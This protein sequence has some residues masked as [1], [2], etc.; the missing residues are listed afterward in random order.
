LDSFYVPATPNNDNIRMD[1]NM[2][3]AKSSEGKMINR[4]LKLTKWYL[5][6]L[7]EYILI[8]YSND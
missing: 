1:L 8:D 3:K 4:K 7:S 5:I 2:T 6:L